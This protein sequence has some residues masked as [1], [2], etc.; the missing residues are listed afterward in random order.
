MKKF[1]ILLFLAAAIQISRADAQAQPI[2]GRVID[3]STGAGL[4]A[5]TILIQ[6]TTRGTASGPDGGFTIAFPAD[7]KRHT[8]QISLTGYSTVTVPATNSSPIEVR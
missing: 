6:G 5:A 2:R 1:S 3:D 4:P 8:L 7:G